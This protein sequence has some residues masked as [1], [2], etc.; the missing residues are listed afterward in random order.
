MPSSDIEDEPQP[1]PQ[2]QGPWQVTKYELT[3][4]VPVW[5]LLKFNQQEYVLT[6]TKDYCLPAKNHFWST[7]YVISDSQWTLSLVLQHSQ[8]TCLWSTFFH[9][10]WTKWKKEIVGN[11]WFSCTYSIHVRTVCSWAYSKL[12]PLAVKIMNA[13]LSMFENASICVNLVHYQ[14]NFRAST[15]SPWHF[16]I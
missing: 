13:H 14:L 6:L 9:I 11:I 10:C 16:I 3:W 12:E 5:I 7:L 2:H 8:Y 15:F 4:H 1:E